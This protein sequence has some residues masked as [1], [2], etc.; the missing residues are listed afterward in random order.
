MNPQPFDLQPG[1]VMLSLGTGKISAAIQALD[2]G[3]YSHAA[4]W[5]GD[6]V[7]ESTTPCVRERSLAESLREHPR[8]YVDVY[9]HKSMSP[10]AASAVV[11]SARQYVDR[12]YSYGDLFLCASLI[13][14]AGAFPDKKQAR[15]LKEACE[16]LH[17]LSLN[18]PPNG[19]HVT[20]T[21]LVVQAFSSSGLPIRIYPRGGVQF[22]LRAVVGGVEELAWGDTKKEIADDGLS[23]EEQ[24]EWLAFQIAL[25]EKCAELCAPEV[26][27]SLVTEDGV[28]GPLARWD[29]R[30]A[31]RAEG[32]WRSNLVTPRNLQTSPDLE[33]FTR[34]YPGP[35]GEPTLPQP[36]TPE[37]RSPD[38]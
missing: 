27:A 23:E 13:S 7:I 17:F 3:D 10:G 38:A 14:I 4:I 29:G 37:R 5:T 18:R 9:R 25:H 32:E 28:K 26:T 1:D 2:G 33:F 36:G 34:V 19:A 16:F 12:T 21:Q 35:S 24:R 15:F 8:E 31:V 30:S 11:T 20:C 6:R 22:D